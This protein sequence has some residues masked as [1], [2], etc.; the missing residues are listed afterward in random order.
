MGNI[1][2][3]A[4][5]DEAGSVGNLL[6]W[7]RWERDLSPSLR[8]WCWKGN[9]EKL[10]LRELSES[11]SVMSNTLQCH[12][13]YSPWNSLGRNTG[14][15]SLSLLQGIFPTQGL[16]LG[17]PYCRQILYQLS[18]REAQEYW[19][20]EPILSPVDLPNQ[21]NEPRSPA[22]QADSLPTDL[23]PIVVHG[24]SKYIEYGKCLHTKIIRIITEDNFSNIS[25]QFPTLPW[26]SYSKSS[27]SQNPHLLGFYRGLIT[28]AWPVLAIG[29]WT[30]SL[31]PPPS[32]EVRSYSVNSNPISS[33][34]VPILT[35]AEDKRRNGKNTQNCTKKI[36]IT[37]ISM[38]VWS[39]T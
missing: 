35:E 36:F 1:L 11:C 8:W 18:H 15:G 9:V 31:A 32:L 30:Q 23:F 33:A 29:D 26:G 4:R 17:L 10:D 25:L 28:E 38:M 3:R 37:Q 12:G 22:L 2:M 19:S 39:L 5:E 7:D 24:I 34:S 13:L 14:V 16:N 21:G 27:S 20:G 6:S